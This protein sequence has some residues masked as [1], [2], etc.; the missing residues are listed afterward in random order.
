MAN[1]ILS[2]KQIEEIFQEITSRITGLE[3]EKNVRLS[4]PTY[5]APGWKIDE[6]IVFVKV[7]T[8]PDAYSQ[9]REDVYYR[10]S[11]E[12]I[13]SVQIESSYTRV[14]LAQ[15]TFYGPNSYDLAEALKSGFYSPEI[16]EALM[17]HSLFFI[18]DV[19]QPVR[20]PE[21]Y[22]GQW[23]ER[24]DFEAKFNEHVSNFSSV[25]SI[26]EVDLRVQVKAD[27]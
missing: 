12:L 1:V 8:V 18:L 7:L 5:G 14:H 26:I 21:L 19:Q 13:D 4:W 27:D 11:L 20:A 16:K 2:L 9:Q 25:S 23:W 15:W 22:N 3:S 17:A 24:V 6:D 10:D